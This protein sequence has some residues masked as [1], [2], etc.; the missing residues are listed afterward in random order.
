MKAIIICLS[1]ASLCG[2]CGDGTTGGSASQSE[3]GGAEPNTAASTPIATKV[4]PLALI[5]ASPKQLSG[6]SYPR[7]ML[8]KH[9][10]AGERGGAKADQFD[11]YK[12]A[13]PNTYN[14]TASTASPIIAA[15][16]WD[17]KKALTISW[18]GAFPDV[19][20]DIINASKDVTDIWVIHY[21]SSGLT[22]FQQSM[23]GQGT[24]TAG[25]NFLNRPNDSIWIRDFGPISAFDADTNRAVLVDPRYYHNR[26]YDDAIPHH[27]AGQFGLN[28][29]KMPV[30]FEGGNFMADGR[31]TCIVSQGVLWFNGVSES[32][33]RDY[34]RDYLGCYQLVI[35]NPLQ[36]EGT[37]HVDMF[38]K[39]V[40]PTTVVLGEYQSFQDPTNAATLNANASILDAV[41]LAGGQSLNVVRI[42]MPSNSG[43]NVW[44]TY[45]NTQFINGVNMI[46]TYSDDNTY[47]AQAL[48][49][50]QNLLP[51]WQHVTID[52]TELITWS[53]AIHCILMEVQDGDWTLNQ[54]EP[55]QICNNFSCFPS[56]TGGNAGCGD[57]AVTG[58]CSGG[59]ASWC[60]FGSVQTVTC[61]AGESCAWDAVAGHYGCIGGGGCQASCVG[62]AC[63]NDGCGGSCGSCGAGLSCTGNACMPDV[64][65]GCG[66]VSFQG[67]CDGS[68][69]SY[70]QNGALTTN[71][72]GSEGCGW[73]SA[74]GY[75]NC[76]G[77]GA[78]PS[79]Q[80]PLQCASACQPDCNG[81]QCGS[82]GCGGQCGTCGAGDTCDG[83]GQCVGGCTPDCSAK[84]CGGDGCG[85][86]CG[87][88]A[89]GQTC[90]G[91]G[92]CVAN[93]APDC[94]GKQCGDD[95]CGGSCGS[96]GAP[97]TCDGA[98]QCVNDCVPD[99]TTAECGDDGCGG[100]CGSCAA[101]EVCVAGTCDSVG[102]G[103]GDVSFEGVCD[104]A[105]GDV[106]WCDDGQIQQSE[107]QSG[108]CGWTGAD[109]GNW[110]VPQQQC[111]FCNNECEIGESGCSVFG[112]HSWTC[113]TSTATFPCRQRVFVGC[114]TACDPGTNTCDACVPS[115]AGKSCGDDGCGGSCGA[116][117]PG[118]LCSAITQA[119]EPEAC[120]PNCAGKA[121][122]D[123]GCGGNC[124]DCAPNEQCEAN[125]CVP[126]TCVP[127]CEG[128][129]CGPDGCGGA[130]GTCPTGQICGSSGQCSTVCVASCE[131]LACGTDGCGGSCGTCEADETCDIGVCT[132][133]TPD[134]TGKSC[135]ADGCGGICGECAGADTCTDDGLCVP[136]CV[137]D[138][139]GK[140]CG[141]DG[142]GG[143]CGA[144]VDGSVCADGNCEVINGCGSVSFQGKCEGSVVVWCEAGALKNFDCASDSKLCGFTEGIGFT[145]VANGN[146]IPQCS[147]KA[148]GPDSCG[149]SCGGCAAGEQCGNGGQCEPETECGDV[150]YEGECDGSAVIWCDAGVLKSYDCTTQNKTCGY[151]LPAGYTCIDGCVPLCA[152]KT[153][154]DDGCG[155]AC[156]T[157]PGDD[158]CTDGQCV[159][160]PGED[161]SPEAE[162]IGPVE[163]AAEVAS[164]NAPTSD[165]GGTAET[166]PQIDAG[167]T[168][169]PTE[170]DGC[171]AGTQGS[172][173]LTLPWLVLALAL[174]LWT[175]RRRSVA[176]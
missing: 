13:N 96:C 149:G 66:D 121:C 168:V 111:G 123:D 148:C 55:A 127:V 129:I 147:G 90:N 33:I 84:A 22:N 150:T 37:T 135:G 117:P 140:T 139:S 61:A 79:G 160:S 30:A 11:D 163:A 99:C 70:C 74:N 152:G 83:A 40:D 145:C 4:S 77:S 124:G 141:L 52:S 102:G 134:C 14:I 174:G 85:G 164:D 59:G 3:A 173:P 108:C 131:G 49:I 19:Y 16:E 87:S 51:T 18:T 78:D 110:C 10:L 34:F 146:C 53:G 132:A 119:C 8:P 23:A 44:R 6:P 109:D 106:T 42:P 41:V 2:G 63:G 137:A 69:L 80:F 9:A 67:C 88:C 116:C 64:S 21:G 118:E 144:C 48:A 158:T 113:A 76:G 165:G 169:P 20:S 107:C 115:C 125:Q 36:N 60:D 5:G 46:P 91:A 155:G 89:S 128:K 114:P 100:T 143:S 95:G 81:K 126:G 103:C 73:D 94:S 176:A 39:L 25:L 47:E 133:C 82:D 171:A 105:T 159:A 72:C 97:A 136:V 75:Y 175:R 104:Y 157:C 15:A 7:P 17:T 92:A 112:T 120:V 27:L 62:K 154:G 45:A 172:S 167:G 24:S 29:F 170:T 35:L 56:D 151:Q 26:V 142:C 101:S 122:G 71:S 32:A 156:G 31:G 12:L 54:V 65:G 28:N 130:C 50:W 161:T 43:Q 138:C 93:C 166:N 86:S 153:C 58:E 57:I 68:I 38:S 1:I 98:G 162:D